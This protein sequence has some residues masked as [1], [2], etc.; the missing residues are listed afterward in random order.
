MK[1]LFAFSVILIWQSS[2]GQNVIIGPSLL[3]GTE[4]NNI[5][6]KS[7]RWKS[8]TDH[9]MNI[10]NKNAKLAMLE[11]KYSNHKLMLGLTKFYPLLVTGYAADLFSFHVNN[12]NIPINY[13]YSEY[14]WVNGLLIGG[15]FHPKNIKD[16]NFFVELGIVNR[17]YFNKSEQIDVIDIGQAGYQEIHLTS[18]YNSGF[19]MI[20]KGGV[21]LRLNKKH[22]FSLGFARLASDK[23]IVSYSYKREVSGGGESGKG[24]NNGYYEDSRNQYWYLN[25]RYQYTLAAKKN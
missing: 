18:K 10:T 20:I 22:S 16:Y 9:Y 24:D 3:F 12:T 14:S 11:F 17:H 4:S 13:D 6:L 8:G 2:V 1:L 15:S 19:G 7:N 23:T 21:D 5:N 25:F